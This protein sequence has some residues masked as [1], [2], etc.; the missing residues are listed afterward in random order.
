MPLRLRIV[1]ENAQLLGDEH[2]KEFDSCGGSI[3]RA[4]D[5]DW[6]L[7]DPKRYVSGRHALIDFHGGAYYLVD[8]SRN[9]VFV[10]GSDTPV[11]RGHPQRLF[12]GDRLRLGA[13]DV[14]CA[15]SSESE[16][17][18]S[19]V[20]PDSVARAQQVPEDPSMELQMVQ[21][22]YLVED[23]ALEQHLASPEGSSRISQLSEVIEMPSLATAESEQRALN[24]LLE[25]AGLDPRD[26]AGTPPAEIMRTA[27]NLLRLMVA[28]LTELLHERA[29][30]KED[31]RISQTLIQ[32]EQNNPL[33]FAP[34]VAEAL[35]YLLGNRGSAYLP[36]EDAIEAS[37]QDI[38]NH[39]QALL[40]A[41]Q[42][43][44]QDMIERFDPEELQMRFDRGLKRN[45][46]LSGANKLKY[47]ELYAESFNV[48]T[49]HE[50]GHLPESFAEDFAKAYEEEIKDAAASS[51]R[52]S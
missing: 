43:A 17:E 29:Q 11:G 34:G 21:E 18:K 12:D 19:A 30:V 15:I 5:N 7:P 47:W 50:S 44:L 40:N 32:R 42:R 25:S 22:N 23:N 39:E 26:L 41:M 49:H 10:N 45:A 6:V 37:F 35:T 48:L 52:A 24:T 38:K 31:F 33:K 46:L 20:M 13:F 2:E 27:G 16:E 3:G 14:A 4:L 1:S 28:G 9:G 36:A 8:T 51:R